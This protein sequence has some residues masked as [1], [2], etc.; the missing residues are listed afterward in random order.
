[1]PIYEY[2]REDGT[3]FE[4]TQSFDD[5]PLTRDPETGLGVRRVLHAPALHFKGKGFYNTDYGT[6]KRQREAAA[7][8]N[9]SEPSSASAAEPTKAAE[10]G[11]SSQSNGAGPA[12]AEKSTKSEKPSGS[13]AKRESA[14]PK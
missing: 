5:A 3:T 7:R 11:T 10:G 9:G 12:A 14:S 8:E 4:L 1:M 6:R 13:S 2:Q